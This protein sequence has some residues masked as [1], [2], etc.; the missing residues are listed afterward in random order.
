M[1]LLTNESC[2]KHKIYSFRHF[3]HSEKHKIIPI[4]KP[5][6]LLRYATQKWSS[7]NFK[8]SNDASLSI[9]S[10]PV[11]ITYAITEFDFP[12]SQLLLI[13]FPAHAIE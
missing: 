5:L 11:A 8:V 4:C 12:L 7:Y 2:Q 13:Q 3:K 9:Y 10:Q 6:E 1:L